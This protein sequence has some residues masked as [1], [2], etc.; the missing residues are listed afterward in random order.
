MRRIA[1]AAIAIAAIVAVPAQA[2]PGKSHKCT[3]HAV[4]YAAA[5]TL[6]SQSLAQTKGADTAK[7]SDDRY[8]GTLTVDVKRANHHGATGSQDYTVEDAR[9]RFYDADHDGTA[10]APKAGDRVKVK[11]RITRLGKKCD[12]SDF[13]PTIT[14]RKVELKPAKA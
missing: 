8:S 9:V 3:P 13:T 1:I 6:E 7:R 12:A 14:V 5:G 2:K 11:G 4:G 10:D